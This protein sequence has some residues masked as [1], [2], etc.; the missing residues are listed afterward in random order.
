MSQPVVPE[1]TGKDILPE[2]FQVLSV[3]ERNPES[4]PT[5]LPNR[6]T[7]CCQV[8]HLL[9]NWRIAQ[10][11]LERSMSLEPIMP[12]ANGRVDERNRAL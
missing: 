8:I 10:N 4:L 11:V 6:R 2:N 9:L 1:T 12:T 3:L 7:L 5:G